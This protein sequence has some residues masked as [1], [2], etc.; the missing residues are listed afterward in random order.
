MRASRCISHRRGPDGFTLL[1]VLIALTILGFGLLGLAAMQVHAMREGSTGRHNSDAARIARDQMEQIQSMPFATVA[2]AAGLGWSAPP[3]INV[4]GFGPGQIPVQI[5]T[6][7]GAAPGAGVEQVYNVAWNVTTVGGNPNLLNV[8]V[9]VTWTEP[10]RPN[11]KPTR[12]GLPTVTL[13]S[14]R[15]N[16]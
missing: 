7:P 11:A 1:E 8:D 6:A 13:S 14:V 3:W 16:W 12:T 2:A 4:A 5:R 9:E 10:N 15:Y